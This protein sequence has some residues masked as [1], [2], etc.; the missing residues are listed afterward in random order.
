MACYR[1]FA[2]EELAPVRALGPWMKVVDAPDAESDRRSCDILRTTTVVF[3]GTGNASRLPGRLLLIWR[4]FGC[5]ALPFPQRSLLLLFSLFFL[6][7]RAGC[8]LSLGA[9]ST[10][11]RLKCHGLPPCAVG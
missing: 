2:A 3:C 6:G 10:V 11:I 1:R 7:A 9:V 4:G 5:F 8:P